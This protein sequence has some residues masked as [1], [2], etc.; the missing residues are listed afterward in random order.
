MNEQ[1]L[2][3]IAQEV[4]DKYKPLFE[5][6]QN[7][8]QTLINTPELDNPNIYASFL[9]QLTGIYG[10]INPEYKRISALKE[11]LEANYFNNL[12]LLASANNEKFVAEVAKRQASEY[13]K[14]LRLARNILE[15]YVETC[16]RAIETCKIH[17]Y[18]KK[19]YESI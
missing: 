5:T 7:I 8:C 15:G 12:K 16:V 2:K 6:V 11:N 9:N 1:E 10:T 14:D 3:A 18:D 13:I 4:I 19:N 17:L